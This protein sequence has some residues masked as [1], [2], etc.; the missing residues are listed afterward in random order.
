METL[1]TRNRSPQR[2]WAMLKFLN[3]RSLTPL[4]VHLTRIFIR[5]RQY[6]VAAFIMHVA[7]K[8]QLGDI[9]FDSLPLARRG[10]PDRAMQAVCIVQYAKHS[11]RKQKIG[12]RVDKELNSGPSRKKQFG[13]RRTNLHW[14]TDQKGVLRPLSFFASATSIPNHRVLQVKLGGKMVELL[15]FMLVLAGEGHALTV[16]EIVTS[17]QTA[18]NLVSQLF[19]FEAVVERS[20]GSRVGKPRRITLDCGQNVLVAIC[21]WANGESVQQVRGLRSFHDVFSCSL[22]V[23][24]FCVGGGQS[25]GPVF[26]TVPTK[27]SCAGVSRTSRR[28]RRFT[29]NHRRSLGR[30]VLIVRGATRGLQLLAG[31]AQIVWQLCVSGSGAHRAGRHNSTSGQPHFR[32]QRFLDRQNALP[33]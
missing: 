28:L 27:R 14:W 23:G 12:E 29:S 21:T 17:D 8:Q 30:L 26:P 9:Q 33:G 13:G 5:F 2:H 6:L 15:H 18:T 24:S 3:P 31:N 7:P 4:A 25:C 1:G 10:L 19:A 22:A 20:V 32:L 16:V 11:G